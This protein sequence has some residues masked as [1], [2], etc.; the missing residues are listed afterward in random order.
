MAAVLQ[1]DLDNLVMD[2]LGNAIRREIIAILA[3]GPQAAGGIAAAFDISRPAI[4][5]HLRQ[6]Q[7]AGLVAY[8]PVG[9]QNIYRLDDRGFETAR[10]WLDRFWPDALQRLKMVAENTYQADT[11]G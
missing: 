4:S 7:D 9:N 10:A 2:A 8:D 3:R 11:D 6:L 1:S 5:R